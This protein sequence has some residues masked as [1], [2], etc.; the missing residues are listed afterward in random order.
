M[1]LTV[2]IPFYGAP[3]LLP[4]A[5]SSVLAQTYRDLQ[6]VVIADGDEPPPLDVDDRLTVYA[7]PEN[8]GTYFATAVA[9][10]ACETEWFT[11]HAADDWSD[12]DRL[13]RLMR[14]ATPDVDA[15]FG[16]SVQHQGSSVSIRRTAFHRGG[17]RPRHVGSIATGVF[18]TAAIRRLGWWSHPEFRV[19]YDSMMVNLVVRH[20]RWIHVPDEHGYHRV[21]RAGSLTRSRATG[22]TSAYRAEA[23]ARRAE[24]WAQYADNPAAMQPDPDVAAEVLEHAGR[25]SR[26]EIAA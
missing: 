20:L 25:L 14:F 23:T 2:A 5:V 3:E 13:E 7:L 18:R 16:G 26:M 1:T 24:L 12:P 19:G 21:V 17:R 15:V 22:L 11:I 9:L 6:V 4:R 10:A 8:R